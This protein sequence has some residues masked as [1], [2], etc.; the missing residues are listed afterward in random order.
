MPKLSEKFITGL[1]PAPGAKDRL[2]FD[3]ETKGLGVRAT[4]N[5][6]K[7]FLV[8]WTDAATKRKVREPLGT[9]GSITLEQ[10]RTAARARLGR[11]AA[12]FDPKA[13]REARKA[14]DARRRAEEARTKADKAFTVEA[15]I[16]D[17]AR[18][19]LAGRRPRY[20][21]EAT[22]ALRLAFKAHMGSPAASLDHGAVVAVL[23]SLS[24]EGK[25]ATARLTLAYGRA[26]YGWAV[27]RRRLVLNP[28]AGLPVADGGG[29]A[30]DRVLS[31]AEIGE[32]WRAASKVPA[33]HG[34]MVRFL[35]LTLARREEVCS[36]TWSEVSADLSTW[37]QPGTRT[38]NGKPHVVHL[39]GAA[40]DILRAVLGAESGKPLPALP[41]QERMVFGIGDN[42]PIT[43][44]S[45]TKRQ[46]DAAIDGER[47]EAA[48]DTAAEMPRWVLHD[49]RRS[50]VTWLAG[51]GFPPHVCDRLLNHISGTISGVAAVYQRNEFL[52]ERKAALEA[53][54]KQVL[55]CAKAN[56]DP[57]SNVLPMKWRRAATQAKA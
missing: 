45:W 26:C 34:P 4:A 51:A 14:E 16:A 3:T 11:V 36:M 25:A 46:V 31:D 8:Q 43:A 53:W 41:A 48:G 37:T 12:G 52:P 44:H 33:P 42:R 35:L 17:W 19:H 23:D 22:R 9:W 1:A 21:A 47:K 5:G 32:V 13:E 7:V 28:F 55:A 18:L 15:L 29:V 40:R 24:G 2:V 50:G 20:A 38:K 57:S 54:G 39:S 30:R 56:A 49:F 10:A 27:K 6:N